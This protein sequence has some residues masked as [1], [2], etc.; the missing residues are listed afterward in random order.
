MAKSGA[1]RIGLKIVFGRTQSDEPGEQ[2]TQH[3]L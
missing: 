2:K 1:I 3:Q